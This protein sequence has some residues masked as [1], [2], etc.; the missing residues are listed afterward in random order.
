MR[1]RLNGLPMCRFAERAS[2]ADTFQLPPRLRVG[3]RRV[4]APLSR[5]V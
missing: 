2:C 5:N 3:L 4:I 1:R